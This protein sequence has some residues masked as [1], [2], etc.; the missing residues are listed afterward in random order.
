LT[1]ER[2]FYAASVVAADAALAGNIA[3]VT[4]GGSGIGRAISLLFARNGAAVLVADRDGG[5][6]ER[7]AAEANA[8]DGTAEAIE[9]DVVA[10]AAMI[11][12]AAVQRFGG[13]HTCVNNA[14]VDLPTARGVVETNDADWDLTMSVNVKGVFCMSRAA[15]PAI[16]RCGGGTVVNVASVAAIVGVRDEAAYAASKGAVLALT[17]QMAVDFAPTIRV[18]ALCPGMVEAPT[19]DRAAAYGPSELARRQAW[20][21]EQPLARYGTHDEIARAAMFLA[22]DASSF[23]TGAAVVVDGGMSIH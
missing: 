3:V 13:L 22:S 12:E 14:G 21:M 11:I 1:N 20:A 18:N 9:G 17:R 8:A 23:I 7:T 15:I 5:A 6:A 10:D 4:G 16:Q 2:S 19:R